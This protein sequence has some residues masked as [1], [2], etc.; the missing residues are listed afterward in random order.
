MIDYEN[1]DETYDETLS[2]Q[3]SE[4]LKSFP[5]FQ[6]TETVRFSRKEHHHHA[7][8]EEFKTQAKRPIVAHPCVQKPR[9]EATSQEKSA[10]K[11]PSLAR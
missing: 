8:L 11:R 1:Y 3:L 9:F 10:A 6:A 2:K 4:Q 7:R 5:W